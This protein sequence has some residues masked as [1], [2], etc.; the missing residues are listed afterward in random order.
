ME[1]FVRVRFLASYT[2]R[3]VEGRTFQEGEEVDLSPDSAQHFIRRGAAERIEPV[4]KEPARKGAAK[5]A[6]TDA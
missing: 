1:K 2:V 5:D 3:D 4:K 6:D